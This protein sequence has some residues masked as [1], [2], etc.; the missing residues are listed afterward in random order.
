VRPRRA[1]RSRQRGATL[2]IVAVLLLILI[3]FAALVIDVGKL[4]AVRNQLQNASDSAAHAGAQSLDRTAAGIDEAREAALAYA[5][6]HAADQSPVALDDADIIFG[7]WDDATRTFTALGSAPDN[8]A[9]VNA[10]RV[11]D[12]REAATANPVVLHLAPVLGTD[13][14]D[15]R[16]DAIAVIGGP[17]AEC[18]FPMVVPDCSLDEALADGNCAHCMVYQDNNADNAG[19][20]SFESGSIGGPAITA[21]ISAACFDEAGNVL[22][23][24]ATGECTGACAEVVAGQEI[25]VQNGNLMN[26]GSANF[27][28][29]IQ[30]I[31]TRG[32]PGGPVVPFVVRVPVLR[33]EA[34]GAC[35]AEQFSS[36]HEVAG[37][38]AFEIQGARCGNS[39]PGVIAATSPCPPPA[40]GKYIVGSLRCDLESVEEVA[41]GGDFGIRS[42]HV[43]LV[44]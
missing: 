39:D 20:T 33:S 16:S 17:R 12:R 42:R 37:F 18:A 13:E 10:V 5:L 1:S 19:W 6:L 44:E 3:G 11:I 28:P 31:L 15:V 2:V 23:D 7:H 27:C 26:Q 21:L 25:K 38:A 14:A 29:V 41:E 34:G 22:V 9:A 8:P 24:P 4:Y 35:S 43:R 32:V 30:R 36:Y 40:S